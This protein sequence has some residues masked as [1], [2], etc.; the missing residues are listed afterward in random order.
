MNS[1][2]YTFHKFLK[3][4]KFLE[5]GLVSQELDIFVVIEGLIGSATFVHFLIVIGFMWVDAL[6]NTQSS[7]W[8]CK[9]IVNTTV[10]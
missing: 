2:L 1:F 10:L 7:V 9:S 3:V 5:Q 6:Q 8:M 4:S